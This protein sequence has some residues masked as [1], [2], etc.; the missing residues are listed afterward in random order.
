MVKNRLLSVRAHH[1]ASSRG[2]VCRPQSA[3]CFS[4]PQPPSSLTVHDHWGFRARPRC[5]GL[6][7]RVCVE[8]RAAG[9]RPKRGRHVRGSRRARVPVTSG[10]PGANPPTPWTFETG[11]CRIKGCRQAAQTRLGTSGGAGRPESRS[12][13]GSLGPTPLPRGLLKQVCVELRGAGRRPKRDTSVS[14]AEWRSVS[15]WVGGQTTSRYVQK[16]LLSLT[17]SQ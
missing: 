1:P 17:H 14:G 5:R 3:V 16:V 4:P 6:L 2:C 8:L 13:P 9:R 11:L 15:R 7:K 10:L 12:R